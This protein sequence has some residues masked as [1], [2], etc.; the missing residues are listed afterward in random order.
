MK[1]L[2]DDI[3]TF[4][5]EVGCLVREDIFETITNFFGV[6]IYSYSEIKLGYLNL[7]WQVQTSI[8]NLFIKQYNKVRYPE[9]MRGGLEV[10]LNRQMYLNER[11]I[12]SPQLL[13]YNDRYV[14]ETPNGERFVIMTFCG[15]EVIKPGTANTGQMFNLGQITGRMHAILNDSQQLEAPLYWDILSKERMLQNWGKRSQEAHF[16]ACDKSVSA[17]E[18]Q[19]K[20]IEDIDLTIF[21]KCEVGWAHW[22]L[23]VDNILFEIDSVSTILDFDRMNNVYQEFD[24]SRPILSCCLSGGKMNYEGVSSFI[25]GYRESHTLSVDKVVR[26]IKLTWWKEAT[27]LKIEREDDSIPLRRFQV[28]NRWVADNWRNLKELF[29]NLAL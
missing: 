23:F 8:G 11:G 19:R 12:P 4:R 9:S 25:E 17:L 24:I 13:S 6:S 27:I 26:S 18:T 20:I 1:E 3:Q 29:A 21:S 16:F 2:K 10:S 15:G 28:E 5:N 7:K 14:L 22:D